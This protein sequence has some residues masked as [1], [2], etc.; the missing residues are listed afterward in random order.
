M[1]FLSLQSGIPMSYD[2]GIADVVGLDSQLSHRSRFA[3]VIYTYQSPSSNIL[4]PAQSSQFVAHNAVF[5]VDVPWSSQNATVSIGLPSNLTY[6]CDVT[7]VY[8]DTP[9]VYV[10]FFEKNVAA[11]ND[12][13]VTFNHDISTSGNLMVTI[14]FH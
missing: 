9:G 1:K 13:M 10:V 14:F 6:L 5:R 2:I 4:I 7:N 8:L 3:H 11:G 12:V